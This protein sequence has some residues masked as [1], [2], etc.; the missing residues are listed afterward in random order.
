MSNYWQKL[1][2]PRWQKLRLKAME[3]SEFR[4]EVCGDAES[5]LNVHHNEYFKGREPWEYDVSQL[6]VICQP[7]HAQFHDNIDLYKLIGS[8]ARLNGPDSREDLGFLLT[9]FLDYD[10]EKVNEVLKKEPNINS[11]LL[12]KTG[13]RAKKFFE[14][15]FDNLM[16]EKH[17]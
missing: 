17:A 6:T 15:C 10:Y 9:G 3:S 16:K 4:C 13:K 1:Q 11:H 8:Y 5:S 12:H 7:C 14:K 2:D